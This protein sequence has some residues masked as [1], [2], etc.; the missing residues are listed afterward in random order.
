MSWTGSNPY[1]TPLVPAESPLGVPTSEMFLSKKTPTYPWSMPQ[2]APGIPKPPNE[3][4]SFINRWLGVWCMF[5]G[6]VGQFLDSFFRLDGFCCETFPSGTTAKMYFSSVQNI[7]WLSRWFTL[8]PLK[9]EMDPANQPLEKGDSLWKP[10]F[11]VSM[12]S[13]WGCM[14]WLKDTVVTC[15]YKNMLQGWI[16]IK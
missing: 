3:R 5:Q 7:K 15:C 2:H 11:S 6:Y 8:T 10:S 14:W 1:H 4:N 16:A 12:L 13:F 9:F